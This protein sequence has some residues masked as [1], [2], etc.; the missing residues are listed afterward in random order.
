[1]ETWSITPNTASIDGN[2]LATIPENTSD[3][4]ITYTITYDDGNGG[5]GQG[6]Y[7]VNPCS[8]PS[9]CTCEDIL[10]LFPMG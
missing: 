8:T 7:V 5:G 1:M 6:T 4:A 2:G 10:I 3:S 9:T